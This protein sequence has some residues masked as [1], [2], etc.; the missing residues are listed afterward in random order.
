MLVKE[1]LEECQEK[2]LSQIEAFRKKYGTDVTNAYAAYRWGFARKD[3]SAPELDYLSILTH[4][5]ENFVEA[6]GELDRV[7]DAFVQDYGEGYT[8]EA[9]L[10]VWGMVHGNPHMHAEGQS[11]DGS[12][13]GV[14]KSSGIMYHLENLDTDFGEAL[15]EAVLA[16]ASDEAKAFFNNLDYDPVRLQDCSLLS[17]HMWHELR[18]Y[19]IGAS[20]LACLTGNSP[21]GNA[22]GTWHK[23][24][25]HPEA[26]Q[27]GDDKKELI[28]DWGHNAESYLR[29]IVL[30]HP[31]FGGCRVL[32]DP[33]LFGS[34]KA[35]Y[36]T[37]NLDAILAWPDGH[38]SILEFKA[39]T[40]YKKDEY[41]DNNIPTHYY[42]QLQGQMMLLNVDDAYLVALFD[43]DTITVSHAYRDLDYEMDLVKVSADFW[44]DIQNET[45]PAING[46]GDVIIDMMNRYCGPANAK[47]PVLQLDESRFAQLL[48]EADYY[49]EQQK[50]FT[51]EADKAKEAYTNVIAQVIAEM[52]SNTQ[53]VCVD[54]I[55]GCMYKCKYTEVA[56]SPTMNKASIL[57]MKNENVR[58]YESVAPYI[59]YRGG[60]RRFT[61]R[62]IQKE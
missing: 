34:E 62:K 15:R 47:E 3:S 60:G 29:K 19:S 56:S 37:C 9:V 16:N 42:D 12:D 38:F 32:V 23:K 58:L 59:S 57:Q 2:V 22:L 7:I 28:F 18:H 44:N 43:R 6:K 54:N 39:P 26:K 11:F 52:G 31:E 41:E 14:E 27:S 20:D 17:D 24:L 33:M 49:S 36:M 40:P 51:K 1:Y 61:L 53:A 8:Q 35:P 48:D 30:T 10:K 45:P 21:F 55:S 5:P 13:K 50:M 25:G 4:L 46:S